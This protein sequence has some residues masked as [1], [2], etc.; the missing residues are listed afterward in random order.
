M[1]N[2]EVCGNN[3]HLGKICMLIIDIRNPQ[4]NIGILGYKSRKV[5]GKLGMYSHS[6]Y[7]HL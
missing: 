3:I 4:Q 7:M 6:I 1:V 2:N 5:N